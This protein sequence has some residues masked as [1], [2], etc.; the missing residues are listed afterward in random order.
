MQYT[1]KLEVLKGHLHRPKKSCGGGH[2][3][4]AAQDS[5]EARVVM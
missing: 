5:K 4:V 3:M 2:G 1:Y